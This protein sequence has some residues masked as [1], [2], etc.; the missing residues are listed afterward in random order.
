MHVNAMTTTYAL[1]TAVLIVMIC[2]L[3]IG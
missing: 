1:L 2:S 3:V